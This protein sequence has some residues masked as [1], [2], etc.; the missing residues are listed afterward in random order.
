MFPL[1]PAFCEIGAEVQSLAFTCIFMSGSMFPFFRVP[2][3]CFLF[4]LHLFIYWL[5]D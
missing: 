5:F 2:L 4:N 1:Q 3:L